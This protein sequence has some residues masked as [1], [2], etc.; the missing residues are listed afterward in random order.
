MEEMYN[1]SPILRRMAEKHANWA[2]V[3]LEAW[4]ILYDSLSGRF[5]LVKL[6]VRD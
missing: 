2:V 1:A 3:K 5:W 4:E 6:G